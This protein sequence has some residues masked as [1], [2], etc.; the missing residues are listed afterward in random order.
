MVRII[1]D[2]I[3]VT[4]QGGKAKRRRTAFWCTEECRVTKSQYRIFRDDE[5]RKTFRRIV[6]IAKR[7]YWRR[8]FCE[9]TTDA[10]MYRM[11]RRDKPLHLLSKHLMV[12]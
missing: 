6:R 10:D 12:L 3:R 2:A 9:A 5:S 8:K 7:Q 4:C 1:S 11:A